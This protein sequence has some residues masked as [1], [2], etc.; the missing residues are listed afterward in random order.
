[1]VG[2]MTLDRGQA[3]GHFRVQVWEPSS[4][5]RPRHWRHLP[6]TPASGIAPSC[7]GRSPG[8]DIALSRQVVL[9]LGRVGHFFIIW[10]A[11]SLW[12]VWVTIRLGSRLGFVVSEDGFLPESLRLGG[13]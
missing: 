6:E 11:R 1:M 13:L 9:W 7:Q 4:M 3:L 10:R 12:A 5:G 2:W 8:P